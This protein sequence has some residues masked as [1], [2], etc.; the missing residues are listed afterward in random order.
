VQ[1]SDYGRLSKLP[2]PNNTSTLAGSTR[3]YKNFHALIFCVAGTTITFVRHPKSAPCPS[4]VPPDGLSPWPRPHSDP[5]PPQA[6]G[7]ALP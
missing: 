1:Q 2:P 5:A 3:I 4:S 6:S 7:P